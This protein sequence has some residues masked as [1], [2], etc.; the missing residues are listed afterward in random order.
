MTV[1]T[2]EHICYDDAC[3]LRK[4]ARNNSRKELTDATKKLASLEIVVDRFHMVG[5]VDPWCHANCDA[6]KI[7]SLDNVRWILYIYCYISDVGYLLFTG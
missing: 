6:S 4:F 1:Y 5:H 2:A 3:H 7:Q